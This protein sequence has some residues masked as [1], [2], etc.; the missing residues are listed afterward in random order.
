M[1]S[2]QANKTESENEDFNDVIFPH[3]QLLA[4]CTGA[5]L[6][7]LT[8]RNCISAAQ[9]AGPMFQAECPT[10]GFAHAPRVR[11]QGTLAREGFLHTLSPIFSRSNRDA[12]VKI[13]Q[14]EGISS[15][16]R[17]M[18]PTLI[19]SV[20]GTVVYFSLYDQIRPFAGNGAASPAV[21]G[22]VSRGLSF[23]NC[24][25]ALQNFVARVSVDVNSRCDHIFVAVFAATVVSPLEMLRT[26][27]QANGGIR[28]SYA[29]TVIRR[30][31]HTEGFRTLYRGLGPTL[32]R[33]VPFSALYW[34]GY[35]KL[36]S[37]LSH[38]GHNVPPAAPTLGVSFLSG[39]FAGSI[40]AV[41]TLPFDVIKTRQQSL[42]GETLSCTA[43]SFV[44]I[45]EPTL[46][47][48]Q[49]IYKHYGWRGF[50]TAYRAVVF[51]GECVLSACLDYITGQAACGITPRVAKVAPAC[52]IMISTYEFFKQFFREQLTTMLESS[53]VRRRSIFDVSLPPFTFPSS[54]SSSV[55]VLVVYIHTLFIREACSAN[56]TVYQI[57]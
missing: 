26:K 37:R 54:S 8:I 40:A 34:T 7:S 36:R 53:G 44:P 10:C 11:L 22:A 3:Q 5:V 14:Y 21:C 16:W 41:V 52:A 49:D 15:L 57:V 4:S 47:I 48:A 24:L 51:V 17:G 29:F 25:C 35:E 42:I 13:G 12:F 33:D 19:M 55:F 31:I 32:L 39:A 9:P 23:N 20:P 56:Y 6:T 46:V 43:S 1:S 38:Y 27:M 45:R 18:T 2:L 50:F 28:Y 30:T